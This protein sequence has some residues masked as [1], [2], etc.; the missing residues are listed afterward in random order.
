MQDHAVFRPEIEMPD[1]QPCIDQCDQLL[2]LRLGSFRHLDVERAGDMQRF[3]P[4][5]P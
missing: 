4:G 3:E 5:H 1:P 2:H